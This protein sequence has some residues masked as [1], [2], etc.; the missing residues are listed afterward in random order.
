MPPVE[1]HPLYPGL[2][3]L[4]LND[5]VHQCGDVASPELR[6]RAP[7]ACQGLPVKRDPLTAHSDAHGDHGDENRRDNQHHTDGHKGL[8]LTHDD[9]LRFEGARARASSIRARCLA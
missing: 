5:A 4:K 8:L 7:L 9:S 6:Q 3:R 1:L 2:R